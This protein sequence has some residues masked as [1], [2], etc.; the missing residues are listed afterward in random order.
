MPIVITCNG[1]MAPTTHAFC[2]MLAEQSGILG[3][4]ANHVTDLLC[5]AAIECAASGLLAIERQLGCRHAKANAH[6]DKSWTHEPLDE[7]TRDG[8]VTLEADDRPARSVRGPKSTIAAPPADGTA[9]PAHQ[10]A[11]R[12]RNTAPADPNRRVKLAPPRPM[13]PGVSA[14]PTPIGGR[15]V[16]SSSPPTEA[17]HRR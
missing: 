13:D 10:T 4:S 5:R 6:K 17:I 14:T 8:T 15:T 16:S 3:I 11:P 7:E 2:S 1:N 12:A 9:A